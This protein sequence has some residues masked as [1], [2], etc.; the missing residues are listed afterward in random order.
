[1]KSSLIN[2]KPCIGR[3]KR[4]LTKCNIYKSENDQMMIYVND[5]LNHD[6]FNLILHLLPSI[7][8]LKLIIKFWTY[9]GGHESQ[10][11]SMIK[12]LVLALV[13]NNMI[14]KSL[15][16]NSTYLWF[17]PRKVERKKPGKLKARKTP[18]WS[19]R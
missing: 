7:E 16:K 4:A 12:G 2:L 1:M 11:A 10:K 6:I 14:E 13:R 9:G 3:K 19:K 8:N 18:Q 5:K 17:D 15:V